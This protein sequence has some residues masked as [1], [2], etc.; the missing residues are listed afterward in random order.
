MKIAFYAPFKPLDHPRPSGDQTTALGLCEH[1]RQAGHDIRVASRLR[2]RHLAER[3]W[4]WP[5]ALWEAARCAGLTAD[6][7]LTHH[8]YYKSPDVL[9]PW[10]SRRMGAPYAV[11]QGIYSTSR[12]KDWRTRLGF[13][14]NRAGLSRADVIFSNRLEDLANLRRLLPEDRLCYVAPG[15]DPDAFAFD[16]AARRRLRQAWNAGDRAVILCAAMLRDDVKTQ[17]V[18]YLLTRLALLDRDFL[19]VLAGDGETRPRLEG[20]AADTLPGRVVFAG[21]VDRRDLGGY[22]SAADLFAFPGI[23]ETLG[24]V[25]LE[26]QA[27]GL[28]V[29]AFD[30]RGIPEVVEQG[31]TGILVEPFDDAAFLRAARTLLDDPALRRDMGAR[32]ARRVRERHD[33][34][35]NFSVVEARLRHLVETR[36]S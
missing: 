25:Y 35:L 27:A 11:F 8:A 29:L 4:M 6:V 17:G 14:L 10:A 2:A 12:R 22:Y 19:L 9:G 13:E 5:L 32:G 3:P 30:N 23:R 16:A 20:L 26:A 1:L 15:I 18:E 24:M 34:R 36:R 33:A 31:G 28:P 7:W 21:Q